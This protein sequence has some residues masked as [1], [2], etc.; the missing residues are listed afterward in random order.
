[1]KQ[2]IVS[3]LLVFLS[4][5]VG[6]HC[7]ANNDKC[8]LNDIVDCSKKILLRDIGI[9]STKSLYEYDVLI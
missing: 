8:E 3:V 9:K 1:M 6:E 4:G 2:Y 7:D 5:S